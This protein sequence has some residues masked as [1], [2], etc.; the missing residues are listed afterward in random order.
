MRCPVCNQGNLTI[1]YAKASKRQFVACDKYP[2]CKT[3]FSLPPN[4]F[5]KRTDKIS[6]EGLPILIALRKGK[7]P[8]EFK[9]D[10]NWKENQKKDNNHN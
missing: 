10:P 8:W 3:T 9:F 7:R 1:K 5:I 2:E 6:P 4:A